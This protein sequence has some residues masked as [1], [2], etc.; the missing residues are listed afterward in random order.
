MLMLGTGSAIA[1]LGAQYWGK[2]DEKTIQKI[3]GLIVRYMV[4]VS[5]LFSLAAFFCPEV[6]M[7]IFTSDAEMVRIGAS[8][9]KIVAPSFVFAGLSQGYLVLMQSM[10]KAKKSAT[11]STSIVVLDL[12]LNA[13]FIFFIHY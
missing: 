8:Y 7:H 12:I 11:I 6:L 4:G 2:K 5:G 3:F 9:L 1:V 13:I 10:G